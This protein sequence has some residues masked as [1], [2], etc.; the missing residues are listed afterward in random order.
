MLSDLPEKTEEA[1]YA[2]LEGEQRRVYDAQ[3]L[4]LRRMI[5]G[6]EADPARDR[7]R[8]LAELTRLRELCCD[9]SLVYGDYR[10]GSAKREALR[11]LLDSA[12]DGGHRTLVFS[13][14]TGALAL[15]EED[16]RE[17]GVAYEK[18]T[19]D[20]P[21]AERLAM[22]ER[23]NREDG[24]PVFL[25]SL[26]AGGTGLNLTGADLVVL[27]DP[28]WN[29]AAENQAADRA[30]RIG[31]KRPVTVYRIIAKDTIE[32]RIL[33]LQEKKKR[34]ADDVLSENASCVAALSR[35]ELLSLLEQRN[36]AR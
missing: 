26:K 18:L 29:A 3:A 22:T 27:L 20:T 31:Q 28:W 32:E 15:V 7:V 25:I 10:G 9:P 4:R 14:F 2:V 19:G 5:R 8:I 30:H 34:L 11:E 35:E 21:K 36:G 33:E 16:L 23:F 13:Q 17:R 24:A 1:R 6:G 12:V